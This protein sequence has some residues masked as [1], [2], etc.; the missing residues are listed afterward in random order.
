M[1]LP[2]FHRHYCESC[3]DASLSTANSDM[4]QRLLAFRPLECPPWA[5]RHYFCRRFVLLPIC[6]WLCLC[7]K[8]ATAIGLPPPTG[9]RNGF[10]SLYYTSS[11]GREC[12]SKYKG[13]LG[14]ELAALGRF[15]NF[16]VS[17]M[18]T[19]AQHSAKLSLQKGDL[20]RTWQFSGSTEFHGGCSL[21]LPPFQPFR[22][23]LA[24]SS[25]QVS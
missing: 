20:V 22:Y 3:L 17:P 10:K 1:L 24:Y 7:T 4:N 11:Y 8:L 21:G 16:F 25:V 23:R 2:I 14:H 9:G 6:H 19:T 5:T 13:K 12:P 15:R 18:T